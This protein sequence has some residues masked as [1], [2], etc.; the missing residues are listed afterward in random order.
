MATHHVDAAAAGRAVEER[1]VAHFEI[2]EAGKFEQVVVA[3]GGHVAEMAG[4][5]NNVVGRGVVVTAVVEVEAIARLA[6]KDQAFDVQIGRVA[7][8][9]GV[10]AAHD[11][12]GFARRGTD[13]DPVCGRAFEVGKKESA[14]V[15][16]VVNFN[17]IARLH[18]GHR[19][20]D[21]RV[22]I[23]GAYVQAGGKRSAGEQQGQ[24]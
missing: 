7:Q 6:V 11:A 8:L 4:F 12:G 20:T 5:E 16:T 21:G 19:G 18:Y 3:R 23:P 1:A 9:N 10:G 14:G 13:G 17:G 24:D 22:G 15:G 2:V